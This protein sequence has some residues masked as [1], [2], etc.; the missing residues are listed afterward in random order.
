MK[1]LISV[2]IPA[3]K[4]EGCVDALAKELGNVFDQNPRYDFE[5]G[6][7]ENGSSDGTYEKLLAIH[8]RDPRFKIVRLARNFRMDGGLT[9]GLRYALEDAA[10]VMVANLQDPRRSFAC[11]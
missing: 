2:V 3:Y 10:V 6:M 4:E 8:S 9:A 1:K 7:V 5:V 11:F